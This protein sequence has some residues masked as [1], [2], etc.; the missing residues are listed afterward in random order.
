MQTTDFDYKGSY[1]A[2]INDPWN[3]WYGKIGRF[4]LNWILSITA[5]QILIQLYSLAFT[6]EAHP[7][8]YEKLS[9]TIHQEY[10]LF[11]M[12]CV[13]IYPILRQFYINRK[14]ERIRTLAELQ[15]YRENLLFNSNKFSTVVAGRSLYASLRP[16]KKNTL[17]DE[18]SITNDLL[19]TILQHY[20]NQNEL[21]TRDDYIRVAELIKK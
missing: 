4:I 5:I 3:K 2:E 10:Y 1:L 18:I 11:W 9:N 6:S 16:L 15:N 20:C 8:N 19:S 21:N 17:M 13:L 12:A 14:I 7:I